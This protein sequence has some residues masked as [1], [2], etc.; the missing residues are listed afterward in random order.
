MAPQ[1]GGNA[2]MKYSH[3]ISGST[4]WELTIVHETGSSGLC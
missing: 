4:V 2:S 3:D 1:K